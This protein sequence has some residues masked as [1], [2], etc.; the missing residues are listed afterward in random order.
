M[1]PAPAKSDR[2]FF[3]ED[4]FT[5]GP[6]NAEIVHPP[7]ALG[8]NNPRITA[9]RVAWFSE[10]SPAQGTGIASLVTKGLFTGVVSLQGNNSRDRMSIWTLTGLWGS[11]ESGDWYWPISHVALPMVRKECKRKLEYS[12]RGDI[13][14]GNIYISKEF[15]TDRCP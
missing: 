6:A 15:R 4:D 1:P 7:P 12:E 5:T 14:L 2:I 13:Q 9:N 10:V 11:D 3:P 8:T